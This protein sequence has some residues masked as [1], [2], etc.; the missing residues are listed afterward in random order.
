MGFA[1]LADF[2]GVNAVHGPAD[3]ITREINIKD[4]R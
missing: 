3:N 2:P 1:V 4:Q